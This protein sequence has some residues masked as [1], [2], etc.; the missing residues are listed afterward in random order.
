[1][2]FAIADDFN[3]I[4]GRSDRLG[5]RCMLVEMGEVLLQFLP[6]RHIA[7]RGS[8]RWHA[9]EHIG[10]VFGA[11]RNDPRDYFRSQLVP[12]TGQGGGMRASLPISCTVVVKAASRLGSGPPTWL[13][14]WQA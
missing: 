12:D 3:F 10:S 11:F 14:L 7:L 9:R 13:R 2:C 1:M 8:E 5:M 4:I 6:R